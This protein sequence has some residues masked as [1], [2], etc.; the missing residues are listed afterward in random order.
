MQSQFNSLA[1]GVTPGT[2]EKQGFATQSRTRSNASTNETHQPRNENRYR[3]NR[4]LVLSM[5]IVLAAPATA[6]T[7][8]GYAP[9][10][11]RLNEQRNRTQSSSDRVERIGTLEISL[12]TPHMAGTAAQARTRDYVI[13]R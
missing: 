5:V 6:Q 11:A 3:M 4:Q 2:E 9:Q 1:A 12:T 7:T 13:D 8:P 10:S